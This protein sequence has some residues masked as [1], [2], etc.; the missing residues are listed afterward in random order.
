MK[1][2]NVHCTVLLVTRKVWPLFNNKRGYKL[3][4]DALCSYVPLNICNTYVSCTCVLSSLPSTPVKEGLSKGWTL[5]LFFTKIKIISHVK[6]VKGF[7]FTIVS[8]TNILG[9]SLIFFFKMLK[10][11]MRVKI[12]DQEPFSVIPQ[13]HETR[14][15]VQITLN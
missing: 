12:N 2:Y 14:D 7:T 13:T 6:T 10:E 9:W 3:S 11:M 15:I 4:W 8:L 5:L 1:H